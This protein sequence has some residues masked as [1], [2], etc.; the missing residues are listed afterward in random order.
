MDINVLA[1]LQNRWVDVSRRLGYSTGAIEQLRRES[2]ESD[3]VATCLLVGKHI[4][5]LPHL[6][7]ALANCER[8]SQESPP[9]YYSKDEAR[10]P[11]VVSSNLPEASAP[12][13]T[14]WPA[15]TVTVTPDTNGRV[16][17]VGGW[18]SQRVRRC[19][20]LYS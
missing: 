20:D 2:Q 16:G 15:P 13:G 11:R 12:P 7:C 1:R 19:Q 6:L 10:H 8:T 5:D 4:A 3:T 9:G 17:S 14:R 18:A